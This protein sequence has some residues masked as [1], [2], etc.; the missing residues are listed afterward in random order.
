MGPF[1]DL[2]RFLYTN[3]VPHNAEAL[4]ALLKVA[5]RFES[6]LCIARCVATLTST[7]ISLEKALLYLCLPETVKR[8]PEVRPLID[9]VS[10]FI[11]WSFDEIAAAGNV[12]ELSITSMKRVLEADLGRDCEELL[13]K[14][15]LE[16]TRESSGRRVDAD[17]LLRLVRYAFMEPTFLET[18]VAHAPEM[19]TPMGQLYIHE[20]RAFRAASPEQREEML[21][22]SFRAQLTPRR[23]PGWGNHIRVFQSTEN[24]VWCADAVFPVH[25]SAKLKR[26]EGNIRECVLVPGVLLTVQL[27]RKQAERSQEFDRVALYI[28]LRPMPTTSG[29]V[30]SAKWNFSYHNKDT[31]AYDASMNILVSAVTGSQVF[32]G[33]TKDHFWGDDGIGLMWH[34]FCLR[35]G[36]FLRDGELGVRITFEK[37]IQD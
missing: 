12:G 16:W 27:Q 5:D 1:E 7:P 22:R 26:Q 32:D 14:A 34:Q 8:S 23:N 25:E 24:G 18:E 9:S 4:V 36:P 21:A 20:A 19:Q 35:E 37:L 10:K 2:I 15:L 33:H 6:R 11:G 31:D 17:K 13:F 3:K 30:I 28:N 29:R